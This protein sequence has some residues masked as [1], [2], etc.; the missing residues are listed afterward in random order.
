MEILMEP[1]FPTNIHNGLARLIGT[2][3][4]VIVIMH[5]GIAAG[6]A[7]VNLR[8]AGD[9]VILVKTE[10]SNTGVTAVT[11]DPNA[12]TSPAGVT[13][14]EKILM[15]NEFRLFQNYPNPFNP[16]TTI[17][18]YLARSSQVLLR[19]YN[20]LGLE[21]AILVNGRQEAGS[22]TVPFDINKGTF[23]LSSGVYFYRLE[24]GSFVSTKKLI[25]I[26]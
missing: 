17:P 8:T 5:V 24:A 14:V 13:A 15:P 20:V 19:V 23:N 25:L 6:P 10:I 22:Y 1:S 12:A 26:K 3:L 16:S 21:V 4:A 9:F 2:I 18:Y 11:L 7:P